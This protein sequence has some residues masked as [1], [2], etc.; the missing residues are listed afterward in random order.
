MYL[1]HYNHNHDSLGRFASGR[2]IGAI[3][4]DLKRNEI[5][6]SDGRRGQKQNESLIARNKKKMSGK[7]SR[8]KDEQIKRMLSDN[9]KYEKLVKKYRT[10]I[11]NGERVTKALIKEA[12]QNGYEVRVKQRNRRFMSNEEIM[13]LSPILALWPTPVALV[14]SAYR[15]NKTQ[16]MQKVRYDE[17]KLKRPKK[18]K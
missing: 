15:L 6:I 3:S 1:K 10:R 13:H 4:K 18:K 12:K 11:K 2:S 14:Y 16:D 8:L 7:G 17:Y 9:K 5:G